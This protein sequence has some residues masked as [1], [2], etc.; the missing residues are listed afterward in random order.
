MGG[1]KLWTL[2]EKEEKGRY[3]EPRKRVFSHKI[4]PKT[5]LKL[6]FRKLKLKL[7]STLAKK[8]N[9]GRRGSWKDKEL[10]RSE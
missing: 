4:L 7:D 1:F 9:D 5:K 3:F 2:V 10:V 8:R 6:D